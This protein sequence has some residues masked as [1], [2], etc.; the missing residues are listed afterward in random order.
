[1][2]YHSGQGTFCY[3]EEAMNTLNLTKRLPILYL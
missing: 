2:P 3:T 1:M